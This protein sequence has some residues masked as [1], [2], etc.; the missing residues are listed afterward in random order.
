[1]KKN[2]QKWHKSESILEL[3]KTIQ[4]SNNDVFN[5][6]AGTARYHSAL[7]SILQHAD[8]IIVIYYHN[9]Y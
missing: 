9:I 8:N 6:I 5:F 4:E 7:F 1:M 2:F 3:G